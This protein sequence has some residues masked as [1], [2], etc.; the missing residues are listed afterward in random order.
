MEKTNNLKWFGWIDPHKELPSEGDVVVVAR[1]RDEQNNDLS[2]KLDVAYFKGNLFCS[3]SRGGPEVSGCEIYHDVY[4]WYK[5][6]E[7][8]DPPEMKTAIDTFPKSR[9]SGK[10]WV[11]GDNLEARKRDLIT[12]WLAEKSLEE[13]FSEHQ[14]FA[15]NKF[16]NSSWR[17]SLRGLEREIKEVESAKLDYT[18][19][20]DRKNRKALGIEYVDCFMYLLD[21]AKRAGFDVTELKALFAE[22]IEIN[23]ERDWKQNKDGSYSHIK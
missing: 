3:E 14:E 4:R 10:T 1:I 13:L 21:S 18:I 2:L 19:I 9:K 11:T 5:G 16:P 12:A 8:P 15:Q 17:S 22:K 7:L 6:I 23:R 20:D